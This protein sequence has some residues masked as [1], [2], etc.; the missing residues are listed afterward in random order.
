M[1]I[2]PIKVLLIED[3][4]GD[5]RLIREFLLEAGVAN[6]KLEWVDRLSQA[7]ERL[8]SGDINIVLTDLGLPDSQGLDG[9]M[10]IEEQAADLPVVVLTG[11][12]DEALGIKAIAQGAQ[13]YMIKGHVDGESLVRS[14]SYA[15]E[16]KRMQLELSRYQ[17]HLEELVKERTRELDR[18]KKFLQHIM[19][20]VPDSL[21]VLDRALTIKSANRS[22][23]ELFQ[24]EPEKT[25]GSN[26]ADV[27]GDKDDKL[28][29]E[30]TRLYG[31]EDTLENFELHYQ[32]EKLGERIL[33]IGARGMIVA[34]EEEEEEEEELVV[35]HDITERKAAEKER[36]RLIGELQATI[37][38]LQTFA[39]TIS[40]D[41][42]GP[43]V[44]IESFARA[45]RA[46][47][48]ERKT[49]RVEEDI[50]SIETG[51]SR[52]QRLLKGILEYARVGRV[53][54][55]TENVPFKE[56][57]EESLQQLAGQISSSKA[58][59]SVAETF[60]TVYADRMRMGQVLNNLI[61]NSTEYRDK[62]RPLSIE[63]GHRSSAGEVVFFVRD[64]GIGIKPYKL[65]KVFELFYRG[66][67]ESKGTGAGLAIVKRIV[68]AHGGRIWIESE[69]GKGT[70]IYFTLP[71]HKDTVESDQG[72]G[73]APEAAH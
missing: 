69:A 27:L 30:L 54:E 61:Q 46:D 9:L 8:A 62:S 68:E 36:E 22:F 28:N 52:M 42:R 34:E 51:I 7:I 59:I 70:T 19:A 73:P 1:S 44:T 15:I 23:Y 24:T 65:D 32:S 17:A 18:E 37:Q 33:N 38:E 29:T 31:T 2:K 63:I 55:P 53:V 26:I 25:I 4:P 47:L 57:I 41:L 72:G 14:L 21:L 60:P 3:N 5:A 10:K 66:E 71:G 35:M 16:R 48:E 50:G 43:L 6:Y 67:K 58:S 56:I 64:N 49:E 45:L 39:Y 20:T 12:R 11:L 40:H 13:D